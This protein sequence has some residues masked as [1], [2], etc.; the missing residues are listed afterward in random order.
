MK[1]KLANFLWLESKKSWLNMDQVVLVQIIDQ[2][3][4]WNS[5]TIEVSSNPKRSSFAGTT[6]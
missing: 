4:D 2:V 6:R 1:A 3:G 5:I